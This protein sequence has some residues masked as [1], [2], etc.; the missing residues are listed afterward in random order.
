VD[1]SVVAAVVAAALPY[2]STRGRRRLPLPLLL[3][4]SLLFLLLSCSVKPRLAR[5]MWCG[6]NGKVIA[7]VDSLTT[8]PVWS[9]EDEDEAVVAAAWDP[10]NGI[11]NCIN[12]SE[13]NGVLGIVVVVCGIVVCGIVV[14]AIAYSTTCRLQ[15]IDGLMDRWVYLFDSIR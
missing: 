5:C 9:N 3:L 6:I 2:S 1:S 15:L 14:C 7:P 13:S 8:I 10:R 4:I 11:S 12:T